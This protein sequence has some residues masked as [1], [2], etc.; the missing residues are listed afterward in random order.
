MLQYRPP[1][2]RSLPVQVLITGIIVALV[3]VLF[4][5]LLVTFQYHWN[6]API[7]YVLQLASVLSL[8]ISLVASLHVMFQSTI[9]E[10]LHW[11]YML[12]YIAVDLPPLDPTLTDPLWPTSQLAAWYIMD[13]TTSGLIQV[14]ETTSSLPSAVFNLL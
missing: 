14:W 9:E 13:A 2:I 11:P 12:S 7:N 4:I 10:S 1:F 8:L 5:H 3:A 6:L